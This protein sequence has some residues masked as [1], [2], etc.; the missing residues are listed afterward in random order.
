MS[1]YFFSSETMKELFKDYL[2][3]LNTLTPSTNFESNRNKIIAQAINFIS[4]NPEDWDKK[5]QY[6]I[7]MIGDTF[8]SFLREKGEDNNSI[9]L[10]FTCFFRF[11]IEPSIL[12]PEIE[13]HFSPLRTI[14]DFALYNYNEFDERSRAQIDFSLR[15]LPLA[16]VKEV[17]SSSN[18]DTYKKYI[19][20][21][22]EGRQFFEKC[23]SFLK[24]Q[25]AKIESIKESLKGYEVAFNFVGLFDGFNSLGKKKESEIMLSRIILI[26]LAII[27]PSPLIYYGMH[28]LPT[29]ETTNAATYFMSAL[30]FASVTLIFMYY[31]RVVL[32]NHISL[33]TQIMQIELRKSLCQ[34]IQSYSD[35]SSEI[36]KNN[37]EA[38]SKF[39]DVVFSNIMLSDDKIPSTFDGI[40][41]IA[42]LINS[43]KNG[44]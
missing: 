40:E 41:Q 33:R 26:I 20:S 32:I 5:S 4:E 12:S 31:F 38:L 29:L 23:D 13:S 34:F 7:A 21:L 2:V 10:I 18:V 11:I 19:D 9:N 36:R 37:P 1:T 28:K 16:M 25:H 35:Y 44:K 3:F 42:S 27:I 15:E 30:P 39:E 6:N 43:L 8:K 14:K 17:L 24:E 22:N